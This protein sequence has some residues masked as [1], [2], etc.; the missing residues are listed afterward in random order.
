M[1]NDT[2]I[3]N[4]SDLIRNNTIKSDI[5]A[6][7]HGSFLSMRTLVAI[8]ILVI[9][10]IATPIFEKINFHYIHES[11]I[12]MILGCLVGL[13]SMLINPSVIY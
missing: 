11:G 13:I 8:L 5:I 7:D 9:Y 1:N 3:S 2:I 6:V 12:C 10:T 4:I